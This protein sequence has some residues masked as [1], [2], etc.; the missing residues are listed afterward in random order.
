M[1]CEHFDPEPLDLAPTGAAM[2]PNAPVSAKRRPSPDA[3]CHA[4]STSDLAAFG[5]TQAPI[6]DNYIATLDPSCER[7]FRVA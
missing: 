3:R 1:A 4:E 5:A 7:R 6:E 2:P